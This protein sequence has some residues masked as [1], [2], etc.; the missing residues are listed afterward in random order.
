[1]NVLKIKLTIVI[2]SYWVNGV[3]LKNSLFSYYRISPNLFHCEGI[4]NT[5]LLSQ[6]WTYSIVRKNFRNYPH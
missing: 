4:L 1:M 5:L 3:I 6:T 2:P